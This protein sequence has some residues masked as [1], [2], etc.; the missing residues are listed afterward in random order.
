MNVNITKTEYRIKEYFRKKYPGHYDLIDIHSLM[1]NALTYSENL[2]FIDMQ[3]KQIVPI[4]TAINPIKEDIITYYEIEYKNKML[5][6]LSINELK[7]DDIRTY[8]EILK[9]LNLKN[10]NNKKIK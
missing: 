7:K 6:F 2:S 3:F 5:D 8:N 4:G 10:L 1:D 9:R